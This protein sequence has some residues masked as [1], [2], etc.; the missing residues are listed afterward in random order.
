MGMKKSE[1][2]ENEIPNKTYNYGTMAITSDKILI[3]GGISEQ[4]GTT[5]D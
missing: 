1:V 3:I 4:Q 5:R 2:K